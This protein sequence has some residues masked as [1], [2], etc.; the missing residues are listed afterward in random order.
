MKNQTIKSTYEVE[1]NTSNENLI[2]LSGYKT[3]FE[4]SPTQV[5]LGFVF[6]KIKMRQIFLPTRHSVQTTSKYLATD[7][8]SLSLNKSVLTTQLC[9]GWFWV[10]CSA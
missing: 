10:I 1:N 2:S 5:V 3:I 4:T 7:Q 9:Q 6:P 8:V